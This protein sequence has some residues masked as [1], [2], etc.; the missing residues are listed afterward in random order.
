MSMKILVIEDEG[1]LAEQATLS[2]KDTRPQC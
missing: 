2:D 1:R